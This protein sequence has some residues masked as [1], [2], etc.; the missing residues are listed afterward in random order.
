MRLW[1]LYIPAGLIEIHPHMKYQLPIINSSYDS[2][3]DKNL[4]LGYGRTDIRTTQKLY[5]PSGP[6][7]RG[8]KKYAPMYIIKPH[9]KRKLC[10]SGYP[11]M[12]RIFT[13][14]PIFLKDFRGFLGITQF[15]HIVSLS[16]I[17]RFE[18]NK[19]KS[20][21]IIYF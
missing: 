21:V 3:L 18:Q 4:N 5:A 2:T 13:S 6:R 1:L 15:G 19:I 16:Y 7:P 10:V 12:P 17:K 11:T 20:H 14:N 9:S 8:I